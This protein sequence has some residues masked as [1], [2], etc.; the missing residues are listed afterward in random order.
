MRY[1]L[2]L[3]TFILSTGCNTKHP[4]HYY[5]KHKIDGALK[6]S[7]TTTV[8]QF[9]V[10]FKEFF[11]QG[12]TSCVF[13]QSD[14][15]VLSCDESILSDFQVVASSVFDCEVNDSEKHASTF[16]MSFPKSEFMSIK[17]WCE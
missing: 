12:E 13:H 16:L 17:V 7:E 10:K 6:K 1:A 14:S 3:I 8:I 2:L 4:T 5:I 9:G 15:L 11:K